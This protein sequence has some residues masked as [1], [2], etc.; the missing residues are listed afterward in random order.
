MPYAFFYNVPNSILLFIFIVVLVSISLI[1]LYL[2][3]ILI[4]QGFFKALNDVNTGLYTGAVTIAIAIIIAFVIT[5]EWITYRETQTNLI[6]EANTLYLI[7]QN[8]SNLPNTQLT[9]TI[10]IQYIS[11]IINIEFPAM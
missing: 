4:S 10:I 9:Q 8:V 11:S 5:N 2:F 3:T 1:G 7:Y 6:Q